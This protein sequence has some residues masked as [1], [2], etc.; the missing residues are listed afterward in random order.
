MALEQSILSDQIR[1]S[2]RTMVFSWYNLLGYLC[3]AVGSLMT[4]FLT[5]YLTTKRGLSQVNSYR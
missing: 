2:D 3:T 1:G 5:D 4:G